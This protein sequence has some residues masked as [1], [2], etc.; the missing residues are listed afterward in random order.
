[1]KALLALL[2][3]WLALNPAWA[4]GY[5]QPSTAVDRKAS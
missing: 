1:M 2:A 3:L 4:D 5:R